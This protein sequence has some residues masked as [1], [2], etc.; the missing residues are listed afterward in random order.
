M[1][2][3]GAYQWITATSKKVGGPVNLLLLTG[4]GAIAAWES[5]KWIVRRCSDAIADHIN[6]KAN[7][8]TT[9]EL[10]TVKLDDKSNE[11][12]AF[13]IGDQF[14]VLEID[15]DAAL[16]EKIGC[17]GNPYFVSTNLLRRISDYK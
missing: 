4:V 13:C 11:G 9:S 6:K 7:V 10:Y 5:G 3:L 1:S 15:G 8:H 17:R 12:V 2:N 16:I 14:R